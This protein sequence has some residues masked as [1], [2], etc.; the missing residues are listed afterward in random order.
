MK[1]VFLTGASSGIGLAIAKMLSARGDE[2]WGT[3][4]DPSRLPQLPR[5]H[6]IQLDLSDPNSI[7]QAFDRALSTAGHFD[8][9]INNAGSGHFGAAE[10]LSDAEINSQFQILVF[11]HLQLMRLALAAMRSHGGGLIV[12]VTSL[13]SRLPVPFMAAYNAAKAAMAAFTMSMQLELPGANVR[14]VDLQPAD[15]LTAF[16]D[17]VPKKE[18]QDPRY[19]DRVTKTWVAVDRNMKNAPPPDLVAKR[20]LD[21]IDSPNPPPRITVGDRFQSKVAPFIFRFLPQRVRVWGLK[22]YYGI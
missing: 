6:P 17:A 11:G 1:K 5:L 12:N 4:R 22:M 15:I 16:N 3:S 14:V 18:E 7:E 2:V 9:V 10:H 8:V 19:R 21:L 20:A 13:A